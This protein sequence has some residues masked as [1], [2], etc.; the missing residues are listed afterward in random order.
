MEKWDLYDKN[1]N[2]LDRK[3][4]RGDKLNDDE[5]HLVVNTW[6][7]NNENEF[8]VSQRSINKSHPLMWECTGGS[9]LMGEESIDAAIREAKE[10]L[11]ISL[12][13]KDGIL[14]GSTLRYYENCNDILD[15]WL[16]KIDNYEDLNIKIQEE[17]LNDYKWL[18]KNEILD[19]YNEGKFEANAYF[20]EI[21]NIKS[22]K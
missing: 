14:I 7:I 5:F 1:R 19:L 9:A 20:N 11:S 21:L 16:F 8:L 15:V 6:I 18:S 2:M 12:D 10:E 22:D 3:A 13:K 4:Y 17:E